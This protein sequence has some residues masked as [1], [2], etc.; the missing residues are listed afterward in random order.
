MHDAASRPPRLNE[1]REQGDQHDDAV[2]AV[3]RAS[4]SAGAHGLSA[5]SLVATSGGGQGDDA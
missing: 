2:H 1:Q 4:V 3:A 5:G